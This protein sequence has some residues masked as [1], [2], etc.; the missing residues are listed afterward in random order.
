MILDSQSDDHFETIL[1]GNTSSIAIICFWASWVDASVSMIDV[2]SDL[3][4]IHK[5]ILFVTVNADLHS[6]LCKTYNVEAVP[7]FVILEYGNQIDVLEG[8]DALKLSTLL[9]SL[10]PQQITLEDPDKSMARKLNDLVNLAPVMVFM[11]GTPENPECGFTRTL[12]NILESNNIKY[13]SFNILRDQVVRE[14][15]KKYSNWPT[16]PQIYKDGSLI[17]GLDIIKELN[18]NNELQIALGTN[19]VQTSSEDLEQLIKVSTLMVFIKGTPQAPRCGYSKQLISILET[20]D[21]EFG[22]FD[23]LTDESVRQ[24][25]KTYSNWPTFPQVY[26]EGNLVGGLDIVKEMIVSGEFQNLVS[27]VKKK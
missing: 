22:Y 10:K 19:E 18:N 11:K 2:F 8:A 16:Y 20:L 12:V 25:L 27:S 4:G 24:G 23:I 14:E 15:L 5:D 9:D 6:N 17:G 7:V 26:F 1:A 3:S 13:K 21:L